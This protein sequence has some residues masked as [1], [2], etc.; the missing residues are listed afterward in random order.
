[1]SNKIGVTNDAFANY[2]SNIP[3]TTPVKPELTKTENKIEIINQVDETY[4]ENVTSDALKDTSISNTI[5]YS[6][7]SEISVNFNE[8]Q[9]KK[10]L[11]DFIP[12]HGKF[13]P[14]DGIVYTKQIVSDSASSLFSNETQKKEIQNHL[15]KLGIDLKKFI[16]LNYKID[17]VG[18]NNKE[19]ASEL[20]EKLKFAIKNDSKNIIAELDCE[21]KPI[22]KNNSCECVSIPKTKYPN[23]SKIEELKNDI[24]IKKQEEKNIQNS[25]LSYIDEKL[26]L[27][28]KNQEHIPYGSKFEIGMEGVINP[29]KLAEIGINSGIKI[30]YGFGKGPSFLAHINFDAKI[31]TKVGS[32]SSTMGDYGL[33]FYDTDE[34]KEFK[35]KLYK[36]ITDDT[37]IKDKGNLILD[38]IKNNSGNIN[39]QS[40]ELK[41]PYESGIKITN[42]VGTFSPPKT[43]DLKEQ[44]KGYYKEDLVVNDFEIESK[45]ANGKLKI[46]SSDL[47]SV[48]KSNVDEPP[49]IKLSIEYNKNIKSINI[50]DLKNV[51]NN[52][53]KVVKNSNI[54]QKY[55]ILNVL[56]NTSK[57]IDSDKNILNKLNT[58]ISVNSSIELNSEQ[59][60]VF[61]NI[62]NDSSFTNKFDFIKSGV[63]N[64]PVSVTPTT[65]INIGY[66]HKLLD[67][68]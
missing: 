67:K 26:D 17:L 30:E 31:S 45:I 32:F 49:I 63:K 25:N 66:R 29:A 33:A 62:Y 12:N 18:L 10:V 64:L 38:L 59:K 41:L 48:E 68:K 65:N 9:V 11:N 37:S 58:N 3:P 16:I 46:Q 28:S 5:K 23:Q 21:L 47:C 6:N 60:G 50:N 22:N 42:T 57:L 4:I 13:S 51:V 53:K 43:S 35:D 19:L 8:A 27:L 20:K 61:L 36:I 7:F 54:K 56:D 2:L 52:L 44:K 40:I 1:M 55:N 14:T 39:T 24:K 34:I 15:G